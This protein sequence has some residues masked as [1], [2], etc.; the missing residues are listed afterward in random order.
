MNPFH[1]WFE[2]LMDKSSGSWTNNLQV[3]GECKKRAGPKVLFAE[4]LLG[5]SASDNFQ[6]EYLLE[7]LVSKIAQEEEWYDSIVYGVL[8]VFLVSLPQPIKNFKLTIHHINYNEIESAPIAFRLAARN[9][10]LKA[11]ELRGLTSKQ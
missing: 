9:A 8:D 3:N 5:F 4:V 2:N 1:K 11:L 7:P 6:I 10:A